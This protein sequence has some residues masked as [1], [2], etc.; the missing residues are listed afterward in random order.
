M[1]ILVVEDDTLTRNSLLQGLAEAGHECNGASDGDRGLC[2]ADEKNPD[3]VIL[4][5]MLPGRSGVDVIKEIRRTRPNDAGDHVDGQRRRW[6][7]GD[8][9]E[10]GGR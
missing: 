2:L 8:W 6:R 9:I 7:S 1:N 3:L 10:C 5:L 4:D